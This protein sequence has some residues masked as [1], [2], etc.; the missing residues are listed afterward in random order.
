MA[1]VYNLSFDISEELIKK[2]QAD[3]LDK[4][5]VIKAMIQ[6]GLI[7]TNEEFYI[8]LNKRVKSRHIIVYPVRTTMIFRSDKTL[9]DIAACLNKFGKQMY[10]V[11]TNVEE[12]VNTYLA[13]LHGDE[14]LQKN[15]DNQLNE[16]IY[17]L[18]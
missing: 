7:I 15:F 17:N 9:D 6:D 18:E 16:L 4:F 1:K 3:Q 12:N 14:E 2:N 10:Y 5:D 8:Y 11:I 13:R